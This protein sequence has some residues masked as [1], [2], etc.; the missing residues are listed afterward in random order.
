M[1]G[2]AGEEEVAVLHGFAH[3][4]AELQDRLLEDLAVLDLRAFAVDAGVQFRP[5]AVVGPVVD[6]V[7]RVD[8]QVVPLDLRGAGADEREAA[9]WLA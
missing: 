6:G 9:G 7:V 4:A 1:G 8:L 3:E 5:D 2:V